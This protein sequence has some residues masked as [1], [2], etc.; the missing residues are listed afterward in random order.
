M[1]V[2]EVVDGPAGVGVDDVVE[3]GEDDVD[4]SFDVANAGAVTDPR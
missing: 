4:A 1:D 2:A 3:Q